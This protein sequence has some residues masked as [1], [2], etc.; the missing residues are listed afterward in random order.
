MRIVLSIADLIVVLAVVISVSRAVWNE[1]R[2]RILSAFIIAAMIIF[3]LV[4]FS[5]AYGL[6]EN[7]SFNQAALLVFLLAIAVV[8]RSGWT[9]KLTQ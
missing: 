2:S 3:G 1:E 5:A 7:S 9:K 8:V 6:A 4:S